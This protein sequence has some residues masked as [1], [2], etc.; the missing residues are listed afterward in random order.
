VYE[1]FNGPFG[2][3]VSYPVQ[4]LYATIPTTLRSG[5]N[6]SVIAS[7]P[8]GS[9]VEAVTSV[10]DWYHVVVNGRTGYIDSTHLANR[11]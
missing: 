9:L 3:A 6:G 11:Y 4:Q 10:R 1:H 2:A 8:A 5:V 7:V